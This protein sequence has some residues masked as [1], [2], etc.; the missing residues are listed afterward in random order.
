MNG[1][2]PCDIR[3]IPTATQLLDRIIADLINRRSILVLLPEG[4]E[5]ALL[6]NPIEEWLA[7]SGLKYYRFSLGL[8]DQQASPVTSLG[9][10][11]NVQWNPSSVPRTVVNLIRCAELPNVLMLDDVEHLDTSLRKNWMRLM[12]QWAE[13]VHY[14]SDTGELTLP[15][16]LC[17]IAP[18]VA[19]RSMLPDEDVFL[20]HHVWW[21]IPSALETRL[22]CRLMN[23]TATRDVR[24]RWRES[25]LPA[26]CGGDWSL[27]QYLWDKTQC[28]LGHL[29]EALR[30]YA[31][32]RRWSVEVLRKAGASDFLSV[33]DTEET[34]SSK[35]PPARWVDL[36][37]EGVLHWTPEYGLELHSAALAVLDEEQTIRHRLW[38]GQAELVLPVLDVLR[39][40]ICNHLTVRYGPDWP[41]RWAKP[42]SETDRKSVTDDPLAVEWGYLEWLLRNCSSLSSE[43]RWAS[44]AAR[45][46]F[47]RNEISHYRPV[48]FGDFEQLWQGMC[49]LG[50]TSV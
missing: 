43:R 44:L 50:V 23:H 11:L 5:P 28:D 10:F 36:W 26:L 29:V 31:A 14:L 13:A 3:G 34:R 38:R 30:E 6:R 4:V 24:H 47:I 16:S 46:R 19:V 27:A 39:L 33:H 25:I 32:L 17:F 35:G 48:A 41:V 7:R 2:T 49:R 1:L 22:L 20:A 15:T 9:A 21:G 40:R 8:L 45:A 42:D 18:A 37:Q 12:R